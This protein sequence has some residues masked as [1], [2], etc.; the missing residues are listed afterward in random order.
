MADTW[1]LAVAIA[2]SKDDIVHPG[3]IDFR[4]IDGTGTSDTDPDWGAVGQ[5]LLRLVPAAFEDGIGEMA[6]DRP[7]PRTISNAISQQEGEEPNS[8]G[9]NDLFWAWGQFIDHDLD[10]TEAGTTDYAPILA[11][12]GDPAFADGTEI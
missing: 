9:V 8:F 5:E 4:P 2:L 10:L 12:A 11:S 7:N 6:T 1:S 3:R